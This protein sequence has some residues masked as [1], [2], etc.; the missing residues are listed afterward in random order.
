MPQPH[1]N[2]FAFAK[3]PKNLAACGFL[4]FGD[5]IVKQVVADVS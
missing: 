3:P 2:S 5:A 1:L 4:P